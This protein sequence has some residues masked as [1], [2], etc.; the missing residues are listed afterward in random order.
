MGQI[1]AKVMSLPELYRK[2]LDQYEQVVSLS[3]MI[4]AELKKAEGKNN[5][6]SLL[7]KKK[8]L[9]EN[10]ARLTQQIASSRIGG[11]SHSNLTALAEVKDLLKLISEKARVLQEAEE[12]MQNFLHQKDPG[13]K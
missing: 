6:S 13:W 7:E 8:S 2:L 3:E 1:A 5:L 10:I 4:L 9:G 12:K 11:D